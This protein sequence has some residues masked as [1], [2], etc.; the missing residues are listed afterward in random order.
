MLPVDAKQIYL[1]TLNQ[2]SFQKTQKGLTILTGKVF[3][4]IQYKNGWLAASD[5][6]DM[7]TQS[8]KFYYTFYY[9][10]LRVQMFEKCDSSNR[11]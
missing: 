6:F 10:V 7:F 1:T 5:L 8:I 9:D 4:S 3:Y 2:I 11:Q